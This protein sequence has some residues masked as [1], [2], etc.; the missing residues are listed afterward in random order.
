[1]I[2]TCWTL[3]LTDVH[4]VAVVL[5]FPYY[6][7]NR[8]I[9]ERRVTGERPVWNH[10]TSFWRF[11]RNVNVSNWID[12][13]RFISTFLFS[14]YPL[15]LRNF[16]SNRWRLLHRKTTSSISLGHTGAKTHF[17]TRIPLI[18]IVQ[19]YEFCE[20]WDF[21]NV[22]FVKI[23][24]LEMWNFW[25]KYGFLPQ[26]VDHS[27]PENHTYHTWWT[28]E[29]LMIVVLGGTWEFLILCTST[30]IGKLLAD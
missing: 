24:I 20:K 2:F 15:L 22:I 9:T 5:F 1:M 27:T 6:L 12:R 23:G 7:E 14:K 13:W 19:K 11:G 17:L 10:F 4:F 30:A 29:K 3:Y 28:K 16:L 21:T 26:C 25:I 8:T 18:L